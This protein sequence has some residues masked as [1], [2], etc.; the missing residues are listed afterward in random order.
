MYF[1]NAWLRNRGLEIPL[2]KKS[3]HM[4]TNKSNDHIVIQMFYVAV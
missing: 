1:G 2:F 3:K 4:N